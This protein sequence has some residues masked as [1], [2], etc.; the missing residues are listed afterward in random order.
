PPL[1][2]DMSAGVSTGAPTS[3][4]TV[5]PSSTIVPTRSSVPTTATIPSS[6]GTTPASPSSPVRDARKGKGVAI[7]EPTLTHDKTFKQLEEERLARMVELVN[8][9]R[10]E[11][12]EQRAQERRERPMTPSQ[13]RQYMRTYVK[14]SAVY[15]MV[16]LAKVNKLLEQF[17]RV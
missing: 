11:L 15:F 14:W 2:T 7:D 9:R 4:S 17:R 1:P 12:A 6:S 13:L 10:K 8:T 3:P 16:G 5:S